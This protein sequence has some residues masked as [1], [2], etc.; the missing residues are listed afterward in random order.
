MK[1]NSKEKS[2]SQP[3]SGNHSSPSRA[4]TQRSFK[5]AIK[6]FRAIE[7]LLRS[8][9]IDERV[10][11]DLRDAVNR[12]RNTAWGV[13][14]Y[15]GQKEIGQDPGS[16]LTILAGERVRTVYNL[17]QAI[18]ADLKREDIDF[19]AG[20]LVALQ[21]AIQKLGTEVGTVLREQK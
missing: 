10:L 3:G 19:Q 16:L 9:D 12:V 1:K 18:S 6:R 21:E 4:A 11:R 7:K 5:D 8:G 15:V 20:S 14:Q 2:Q 13:Q 17:C